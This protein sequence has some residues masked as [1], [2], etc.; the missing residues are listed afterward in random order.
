MRGSARNS[1]P[2]IVSG[3]VGKPAIILEEG[4]PASRDVTSLDEARNNK[5]PRGL[6]FYVYVLGFV[7]ER[8]QSF[9]SLESCKD[10]LIF[11][12]HFRN[13]LFF[14]GLRRSSLYIFLFAAII[15]WCGNTVTVSRYNRT[16]NRYAETI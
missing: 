3:G 7:F 15:F 4:Y 13:S 1:R 14:F 10:N 6:L 8:G 12:R 16:R 9:V 2:A 5:R 11:V